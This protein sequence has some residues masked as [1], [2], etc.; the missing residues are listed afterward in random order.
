MDAC[1]KV[2]IIYTAFVLV[3]LTIGHY[4]A[5]AKDKKVSR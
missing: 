3:V 4:I 2:I 1:E 5:V